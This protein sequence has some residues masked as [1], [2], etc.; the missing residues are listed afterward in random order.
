MR[1]SR[2]KAS[3]SPVL[4]VNPYDLGIGAKP[5]ELALG[6]P[7]RVALGELDRL[8]ERHL[9]AHGGGDLPI[10]DGPKRRFAGVASGLEQRAHLVDEAARDHLV[11]APVDRLVQPLALH[12]EADRQRL[13]LARGKAMALL[14]GA[15]RLA[16]QPKDLE[17]AHDTIKVAMADALGRGRVDFG[18][19]RVQIF[20]PVLGGERLQFAAYLGRGGRPGEDS[21]AQHAQIKAAAADDHHVAA[22]RGDLRDRRARELQELRHVERLVDRADVQQM[23]RHAAAIR[24]VRLGRA[25]IHPAIDLARVGVDD[26]RVEALGERHRGG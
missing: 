25:D 15:Y 18:Q 16:R 5:G 14:M 26:F 22:A 21:A 10:A 9:A 13:V 17:R 1:P 6:Q 7:A 2:L 20:D 24:G 4:R 19:A 3:C 12:R 11:E 23:M 8:R